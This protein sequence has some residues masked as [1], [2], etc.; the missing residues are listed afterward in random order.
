MDER[1][2]VLTV[3]KAIDVL[4]LFKNH[5]KLAFVEIQEI[6]KL[7]K[8]TL[9]R[10][11]YTL[12]YNKYLARDKHGRY[13]LGINMYILGS[14][15]SESNILRKHASDHLEYLSNKTNLTAHLGI[16][17]GYEVIIIDKHYPPNN[18]KMVSRIGG[19]V[20]AHCTGQGKALLAFSPQEKVEK[21]IGYYGMTKYTP[22]TITTLDNLLLELERIRQNGYAIDNSEHEKHIK[23]IAVPLLNKEKIE[24]AISITGVAAEFV[25][26]KK[27]NEYLRLLKS[28]RD[29]IK[30]E[31]GFK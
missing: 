8:A 6:L 2:H 23:C 4:N 11:L 16:L 15:V 28:T 30:E 13:E 10:I 19:P 31:L 21:I 3:Q 25:D 27:A 5:Q 20:P 17:E 9:F 22:N 26:E 14:Q 24:A 7:S 1:Y 29:G 18:I 12:E